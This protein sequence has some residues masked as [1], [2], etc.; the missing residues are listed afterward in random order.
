MTKDVSKIMQRFV[1]FINTANEKLA[2]ELIH[3]SA[4]FYVPGHEGPMHGPDGYLAIIDMMRSGFPD[5]QWTLEEMIVEG[6]KIAA[7]F[8][9]H[10]THKGVFFGVPA[11]GSRISVRAINF[12]Y[13]SNGQFVEEFGGPDLLGLLVQI[14]AVPPPGAGKG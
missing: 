2:T 4:K 11:T 10:G 3:P 12:Y 8:V 1:E 14:G 13:L 7:R 5:I 6:E 9:M